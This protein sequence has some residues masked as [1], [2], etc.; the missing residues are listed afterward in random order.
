MMF[1]VCPISNLI[2]EGDNQNLSLKSEKAFFGDKRFWIPLY[3]FNFLE[4]MTWIWAL[5]IWSDKVN[6]DLYWFQ[7]KPTTTFET[8]MFTFTCGYF[9]GVNA[10]N[11][12]ELLHKKEWYNKTLGT[13]CYTKFM[14]SHFLDEHIKGHHKRVATPEDPASAK[15]DQS[16]YSF[17]FQSFLGS[18]V[19]VWNREC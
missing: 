4:T 18:H 6:I 3:T 13:W 8:F 12:H 15:K 5:I 2:T 1:L 19:E 7:L 10:I 11:G 17:I 16:V 9:A 14:Y